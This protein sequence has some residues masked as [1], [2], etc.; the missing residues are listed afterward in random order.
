MFLCARV[1]TAD[2]QIDLFVLPNRLG[3]TQRP[4]NDQTLLCKYSNSSTEQSFWM[5]DKLFNC[6]GITISAVPLCHFDYIQ[7][8]NLFYITTANNYEWLKNEKYPYVIS[9]IRFGNLQCAFMWDRKLIWQ[10]NMK[11]N[12]HC[13]IER[14]DLL[15]DHIELQIQ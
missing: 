10:L 1:Q 4:N 13:W 15:T 12:F 6:F 8:S 11:C 14:N 3:R 9:D 7:I 2:H 5:N